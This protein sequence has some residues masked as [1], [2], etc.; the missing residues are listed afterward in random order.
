MQ[1]HDADGGVALADQIDATDALLDAHRAPRHVVVDER[2]AELEVQP[3]G[4]GVGAQ[5]QVGVAVAVAVAVAEPA[6]DLFAVDDSPLVAV[7][8]RA[9]AAAAG[10]A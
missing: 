6:L 10:E 1:V 2:A 3:L 5:Q 7:A 4:C 8:D 9:L